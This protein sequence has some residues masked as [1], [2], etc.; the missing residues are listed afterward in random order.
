MRKKAW[1]KNIAI[2]LVIAMML[3]IMPMT[4]FAEGEDDGADATEITLIESDEPTQIAKAGLFNI[5][6]QFTTAGSVQWKINDDVYG[7]D[8][9]YTTEKEIDGAFF[10]VVE[11]SD[12]NLNAGDTITATLKNSNDETKTAIGQVQEAIEPDP[13]AVAQ[14]G[15]TQ[16]ETL[17]EAIAD[18]VD[19]DTITLL[20]DCELSATNGVKIYNDIVIEGTN[21]ETITVTAEKLPGDR[22]IEIKTGSIDKGLTLK[23]CDII[24][25]NIPVSGYPY[26]AVIIIDGGKLVL[27]NCDM[28]LDGLQDDGSYNNMHGFWCLE[29]GDNLIS[30]KNGSNLVVKNFAH[31]ALE[32]DEKTKYYFEV[33]DS[34]YTAEHTRSGIVGTWDVTFDNAIVNVVNNSGSGSN[35]ANYTIKD[36]VVNYSDNKD[37]GLSGGKMMIDNSV[38]T[39]KGN[40]GNGVHTNNVLTIQNKSNVI[41]EDNACSISSQWTIPGALHIGSGDSV[42]ENSKVTIQNNRGS[43]IFQKA[44]SL[45][46]KDTADVTIVKNTAEKLG[47]G[48]GIYVNNGAEV[49]LANNV[50]LYNNHATNAADDIYNTGTITFGATG[51]DWALDGEPDC[52]DAIDGWYDDSENNRWKAHRENEN[53]IYHIFSVKPNQYNQLLAVKAAHNIIVDPVIPVVPELKESVDINKTATELKDDKTTVTLNVGASELQTASDVVFVLD[54]STS[55]DVR[56]EAIKMLNELKEQAENNII[57]VGVVVFNRNANVVLNLTELNDENMAAIETAIRT[58]MTSGTNI[59]DGLAKGKALLD[60]DNSVKADAK[61]LVLVTDGVTYLWGTGEIP[62]SIYSEQVKGSKCI[63]AGNYLPLYKINHPNYEEYVEEFSN[64][65]KWMQ[66]YPQYASYIELYQTD[67]VGS[68]VKPENDQYSMPYIP[69]DQMPGMANANDAAVYMAVKEYNSILAEGYQCYAYADPKYAKKDEN[70]YIAEWAPKWVASLNTIGG[71]SSIIPTDVTGMFDNVKSDII[72]AINSGVV[73]D[74]IGNNFDLED[75]NTMNLTVGGEVVTPKEVKD[76]VV[77]FGEAKDGVYPYTVA[78]AKEA[79]DANGITKETLTWS[80]NV[81]VENAKGLALSYDLK[82]TIKSDVAGTYDV[83]TNESAKLEYQDPNGEE[84]EEIFP[85]PEIK[86]TVEKTEPGPGP[87]PGPG[88]SDI[89]RNVTKVWKDDAA[90]NRP[91]SITVNILYDGSVHQKVTLNAANDWTYAWKTSGGGWTVEEANVP[92][93]YTSSVSTSGNDFIITNTYTGIVPEEPITDPDVPTTEPDVPPVV[94]DEPGVPTTD[95]PGTPV[96][97]TEIAEPEVP[98][99]DAPKTGDAAPM[100]AFVGLMAAAVVGLVITRRKFN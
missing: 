33:K 58:E 12:V 64:I 80:I 10:Y 23:D 34:T 53:D 54:K 90:A 49:S 91:D 20:K 9:S 44:G 19:G 30:V 36:S 13:N 25:K 92:A 24:V 77:C 95:I 78:Y 89:T 41:I 40:G 60:A 46:V 47:L 29:D 98:L 87:G 37:H 56:N 79:A 70:G 88:N 16:Y 73:T 22:M 45:V 5:T 3:T 18:A 8:E 31:N 83:P 72:Y 74:V 61:H 66:D 55:V 69:N 81:P 43:G 11:L 65:A 57:K 97:P 71:T 94:I 85:V 51:E 28:T 27:D 39:A 26:N 2:L 21:E 6:A 42:I 50:K 63:K 32:W 99:G 84:Q 4:V 68:E 86:Y 48:G 82:L 59:Q 1:K 38:I 35:G 7:N 75:L 67:Y 14:I 93:G 100:V 96:N 76:N 62:K 52:T 15:D 17:D